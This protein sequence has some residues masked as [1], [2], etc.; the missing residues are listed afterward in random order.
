MDFLL[1]VFHVC[2]AKVSV[3]YS[4]AVTYR[5]RTCIFS[6]PNQRTSVKFIIKEW[7][8]AIVNDWLTYCNEY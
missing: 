7:K 1:F 4:L 8:A 2:H 6:Q 5:E 3:L